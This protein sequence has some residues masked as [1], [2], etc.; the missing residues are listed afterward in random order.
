MADNRDCD[1]LNIIVT[2]VKGS[3]QNTGQSTSQIESC[4]KSI[5]RPMGR[6]LTCRGGCNLQT[7][8]AVFITQ[9]MFYTYWM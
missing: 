8:V 3:H 7:T 5:Y 9:I 1:L 4:T 2:V 6:Q